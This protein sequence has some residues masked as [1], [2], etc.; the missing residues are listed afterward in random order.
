[1]NNTD[2]STTLIDAIADLQE[3]TALSLVRQRLDAGV[4][5]LLIIEDC[6][7]GMRQVGERYERHEYY[8]AGLIMAGEIF[9]R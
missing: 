2:T 1:M 9:S 5:S 6:Q 3:E 8:L 7:Q 4:D